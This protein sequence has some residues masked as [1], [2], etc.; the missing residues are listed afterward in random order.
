MLVRIIRWL[1][2][3]VIFSVSG[4]YPER[5]INILNKSGVTYWSLLPSGKSYT[6]GMLL[7]D[8]KNIR[9]SAKKASV[10]LRCERKS[11]LPFMIKRYSKRKGVL[12]GA[13]LA[14]ILMYTLS[15]FVWDVKVNG[16]ETLSS[17]RINTALEECGLKSG[18]FKYSL[19]FEKIE[20]GLIMKVP[21]IRWISIN[22]L[23][24]IAEVEIKER[25]KKPKR[26]SR[27]YP[28]NLVAGED[29]IITD[30]FISGGTCEV[31]RGSAVIKNQLLVNCVVKGTNEAEDKLSFVHSSGKVYADVVYKKSFIIPKTNNNIILNQNYTDK[32]NL[33]F[34]WL[35][36]PFILNS[37]EHNNGLNIFY[38]ESLSSNGVTL[39]LGIKTQR[40]YNYK[41]SES[42]IDNKKAKIL[43]KKKA[44]LSEAFNIGKYRI[45]RYKYSFKEIKDAYKLK[46]KYIVNKNIAKKQRVKIIKKVE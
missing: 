39:P 7:Y 33:S 2:G 14:L 9:S 35:E 26:K 34:L 17:A 22:A 20:R 16:A 4:N 5:F 36:L 41:N 31:K 8:Y 40:I 24:C 18:A 42:I 6:G 43:L 1:R 3:Y 38:R 45:K 46:V 25:F 28:C 15:N 29:G 12:I 44:I 11:G 13:V 27:K 10:K 19:D 23:N 37:P 21:E 32:S 30:T